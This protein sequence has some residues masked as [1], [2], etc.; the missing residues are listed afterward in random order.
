MPSG[1]SHTSRLKTLNKILLD[2][3]TKH[4]NSSRQRGTVIWPFT[5]SRG[6]DKLR[7]IKLW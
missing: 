1:F 2:L 4:G 7:G 5:F 3:V 6:L